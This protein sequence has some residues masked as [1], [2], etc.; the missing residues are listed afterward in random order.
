LSNTKLEIRRIDLP[1]NAYINIELQLEEQMKEILDSF[2]CAAR[3]LD[4]AFK[5]PN[6]INNNVLLVL[7]KDGRIKFHVYFYRYSS[8]RLKDIVV[9]NNK[10]Q[11]V[12]D[13]KRNRKNLP[14][15]IEKLQMLL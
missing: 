9:V 2:F 4:Y 8:G 13:S 1:N 11:T 5:V 14:I 15:V 6:M 12:L 7:I 3:L 10:A